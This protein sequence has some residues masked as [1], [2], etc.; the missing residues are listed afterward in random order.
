MTR[1]KL[2]LGGMALI[3]GSVWSVPV[4]GASTIL[5]H[6][7]D[8]FPD[9]VGNQWTYHGEV[10]KG[11][12]QSVDQK[13]FLNISTITGTETIGGVEVS[14]FHETN[15]GNLGA[16]DNY[17]RRDAAGI[18]YYGRTPETPLEKQL[19]PYQVMTFPLTI[20]SSHKLWYVHDEYL[21]RNARY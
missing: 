19:V 16:F 5:E 3:L 11:P 17:Y 21:A 4:F 13:N 20:P 15:Q 1:R 7:E 14:V 12:L 8:F 6:S 18:R 9:T 10:R 2:L